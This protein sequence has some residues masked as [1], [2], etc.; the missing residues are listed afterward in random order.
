MRK[1]ISWFVSFGMGFGMF[2]TGA[3]FANEV[4][5]PSS[6]DQTVVVEE[7]PP[8]EEPVVV[9][10]DTTTESA[11]AEE[12]I[13]EEDAPPAEDIVIEDVPTSS[14]ETRD[15]E[16]PVF[17]FEIGKSNELGGDCFCVQGEV[18]DMREADCLIASGLVPPDARSTYLSHL[19]LNG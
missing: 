7:A 6:E 19:G 5:V 2:V 17:C 10:D 15:W 16:N 1:V 8:A 4:S 11:P 14:G 18:S 13:V 9:V 3:A 12:I